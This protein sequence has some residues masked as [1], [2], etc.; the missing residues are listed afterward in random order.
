MQTRIWVGGAL[1]L[2]ALVAMA[3]GAYF[4]NQVA[5]YTVDELLANPALYPRAPGVAQVPGVAQAAEL[6]RPPA[7]SAPAEAE[8]AELAG[9]RMQVRGSIDRASVER[10]EEGLALHFVMG[11]K[12]GRLPVRYRGVVPDTFDLADTV[13]VGGR[14]SADGTLVADELLVQCPSKY[15]AVPPGQDAAAA[16]AARDG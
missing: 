9:P 10:A 1:I 12:D 11:G 6:G 5:Y 7:G 2:G 14:L 4:S 8:P 16:G 13:T 3:I 15:E